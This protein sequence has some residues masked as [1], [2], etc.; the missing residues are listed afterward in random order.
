MR[1]FGLQKKITGMSVLC[2]SLMQH[3]TDVNAG[4]TL[5]HYHYINSGIYRNLLKANVKQERPL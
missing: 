5:P 1:D 4:S 2:Q 3:R